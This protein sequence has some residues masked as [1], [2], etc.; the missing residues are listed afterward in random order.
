MGQTDRAG[1]NKLSFP[2]IT[3][4]APKMHEMSMLLSG[5]VVHFAE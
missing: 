1:V 5:I 4:Y 3:F 2:P